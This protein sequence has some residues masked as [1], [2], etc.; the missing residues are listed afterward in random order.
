MEFEWKVRRLK[1]RWLHPR[2]PY[3]GR[4]LNSQLSTL[5]LRQ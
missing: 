2:N 3:G 4:A 5:E 1:V